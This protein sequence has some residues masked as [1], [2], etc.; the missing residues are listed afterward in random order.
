MNLLCSFSININGRP[1]ADLVLW[2]MPYGLLVAP[3][4]NLLTDAEVETFFQQLAVVQR[5]R[6]H[7]LCLGCIWHDTGRMRRFMLEH[8]YADIHIF[9]VYKPQQNTTGMEWIYALELYVVG[10][11]QNIRACSL[12]FSDMNPV[13]RHN[14]IF[15]HQVAS[16]L[17]YAGLD[18]E[19]NTTQKNPNIA[20]FLGRI[21][22]KA[23]ASAL[24]IGAG[25]GSEVLGLARIGVN[26][27]A[28]E[29]DGKQFRAMTERLTSE[30]AFADRAIAQQVQEEKEIALL[31]VL[32]SRFTKLDPDV[33]VHFD[34]GSESSSRMQ[35]PC[36]EELSPAASAVSRGKV[37]PSCG[38]VLEAE[39]AIACSVE[40]CSAGQI[41]KQCAVTCRTCAV[42]FCS[43][44][45][46]GTH[47]HE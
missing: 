30:A 33:G 11:K 34:Q 1:C 25:S 15:S 8:G 28:L 31:T 47:S 26:V 21:T 3:W 9:G 10:Y 2:D 40:K 41:H 4:D 45:C 27:V 20:S 32:A 39:D 29:R 18:E 43:D 44:Q 12:T 16:K 5:S 35:D 24:V 36:R 22:C 13:F 38:E 23:G 17:K 42:K 37:C 7:T 46:A 6:A 19:V 14:V